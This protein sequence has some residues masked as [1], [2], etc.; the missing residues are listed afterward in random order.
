VLKDVQELLMAA[1]ASP[2][3]VA[4][5]RAELLAIGEA[6][7]AQTPGA[8]RLSP[9]ELSMLG[10]LDGDGLRLTRL[11]VQKLRLERLL[12]GDPAAAAALEQD[13]AAFVVRFRQYCAAVP[14]TAVFPS[15]EAAAFQAFE[16]GKA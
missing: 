13:A 12:L 10:H 16:R 5:L 6:E 11:L 4:H 1:I 9:Q 2:D 15:E 7:K 8:A 3:P 14:P